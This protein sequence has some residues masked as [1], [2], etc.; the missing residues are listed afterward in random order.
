MKINIKIGNEIKE[1]EANNY[2]KDRTDEYTGEL[3]GKRLDRTIRIAWFKAENP[4][5]VINKTL[6][7]SGVPLDM[8]KSDCITAE[9]IKFITE[10]AGVAIASVEIFKD[11]NDNFPI[12]NDYAVRVA[13]ESFAYNCEAAINAATDRALIS[14]GYFVPEELCYNK[15]TGY[16]NAPTTVVSQPNTV[17]SSETTDITNSNITSSAVADS[18]AALESSMEKEDTSLYQKIWNAENNS[19]PDIVSSVTTEPQTESVNSSIYEPVEKSSDVTSEVPVAEDVETSKSTYSPYPVVPSPKKNLKLMSFEELMQD[20]SYEE[21]CNVTIPSG[22]F[23]GKTML[24]MYNL[25]SKKVGFYIKNTVSDYLK[26]AAMIV[27]EGLN[28]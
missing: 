10:T 24:E 7:S 17:D 28:K 26:A 21:A 18:L 13:T 12:A 22:K 3:I 9:A 23:K 1:I 5:G 14:A 11:G 8:I 25:D 20:M 16:N 19:T 27:S 6:K 4:E 2:L 15:I